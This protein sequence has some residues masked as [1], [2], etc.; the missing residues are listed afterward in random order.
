LSD[1]LEELDSQLTAWVDT[2]LP[3]VAVS[4]GAP[5]PLASE[6]KPRVGLYLF[7]LAE[8][9]PGRTDSTRA[10]EISARYLVT[11]WASRPE[12]EHELL[13][14]LLAAAVGQG[15]DF[16]LSPIPAEGWAAFGLPP[17]PHFLLE[18][19]LRIERPVEAAPRVRQPPVLRQV[20]VVALSGR[21]V[22]PRELPI[23]GAQLTHLGLGAVTTTD[24][25]GRFAFPIAPAD[26]VANRLQVTAKGLKQVFEVEA[27]GEPVTLRLQITEG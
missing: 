18:E 4:L 16:E 9:A 1:V 7:A 13:G 24:A 12:N 23:A 8:G 6:T 27:G 5:A 21:V 19:L 20:G 17:R 2:I 15:R 11:T 22:G 26:L 10:R 14:K 3:G 25:A